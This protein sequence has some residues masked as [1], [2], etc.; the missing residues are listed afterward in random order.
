[1][2]RFAETLKW[3]DPWFR[4][5]SCAGKMLWFYM[6]DHC[7]NIGLVEIDCDLV[8]HDCGIEITESTISELG[9]R[10]QRLECGKIFLPKFI[11]FQYGSL[12]A[13][14]PAHK[15]VIEA[16]ERHGLTESQLG[17]AYPNA[18]VT[19]PYRIGRGKDKDNSLME[20]SPERNQE[21]KPLC[22][23]QQAKSMAGQFGLTESEAEHWWH[24]RNKAGWTCGTNGGHPRKITSAQSDMAT[25]VS[26]IKESAAK[27]PKPEKKRVFFDK[28]L[29]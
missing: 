20:E 13:S 25:S 3:S 5:L 29:P 14:C 23:I 22:T 27:L 4:R 8:S 24:V 10:V 11:R 12:S 26:W 15:K 16:V 18:R 9:N 19:I 6:L 28:P 2:K 17:Y 7:D 21:T 1:M